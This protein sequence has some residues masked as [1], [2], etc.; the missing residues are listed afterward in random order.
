MKVLV[1]GAHGNVASHV[2]DSLRKRGHEVTGGV[3]KQDQFDHVRARGAEPVMLD[4]TRPEQFD[5]ALSGQEAVIFAAGS[6]G[7]AVDSVDRDGA[8]ALADAAEASGV[9]RFVMLSSMS[10]DTP[11]N[12]PEKLQDYL[13][14]KKEAD[15]HL[16][17]TGLEATIV[18]PGSLSDEAPTGKIE[19]GERLHNLERSIT[20][21][22]VAET[23]AEVLETPSTI[24]KTFEM[25]QG[26]TPIAQAVKAL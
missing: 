6:G 23:L 5:A 11:E 12:G 1:A 20:R 16:R 13:K 8:I 14:A 26:D 2:L 24:G 25:L 19:T 18:R 10:A 17:K 15:A 22:D 9:S 21:A 4:L 3:R 7:Q